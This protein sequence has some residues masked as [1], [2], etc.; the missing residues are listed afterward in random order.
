MKAQLKI[1]FS[2]NMERI[3]KCQILLKLI[4]NFSKVSGY[5]IYVQKLQAFVYT[6]NRLKES[7]IKNE[8]PLTVATK[9]IK[10]SGIQLT[11]KIRDLLSS[12]N[13]RQC[14]NAWLI[15]V[16]LVDTGFHNVGRDGL[17]LLALVIHLP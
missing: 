14:H 2:R 15:F 10:Y 8:L 9:R 12:W 13:Y 6:N 16:F 1:S 5:K 3:T 4:S 7:Q 11:T 17:E